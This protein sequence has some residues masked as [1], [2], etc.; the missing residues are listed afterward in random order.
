MD[1]ASIIGTIL[2]VVLL[3]GAMFMA[4]SAGGLS[5]GLYWDLTS[6]IIV[7]G[8]SLAATAIAF[9]LPKV[10]A[11][12]KLM[13][14]VFQKPPWEQ[15]ELAQKIIELS[16][17]A[18]KNVK[19]LQGEMDGI[20][21]WFLKDGVQFIIDGVQP[22]EIKEMMELRE[23]TRE[24]KESSEANVMK[25]MGDF[26]PAFGM[27]GTLIGLVIMMFSMG[28]GGEGGDDDGGGMAA[29]L[30]LSMGVALITT[31]YGALFANLIFLPFSEKLKSKN[32][33]NKKVQALIIEGVNLLAKKVH[34]IMV[35]ERLNSYLQPADRIRGEE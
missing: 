17:V 8:G 21:N 10:I 34:P 12:F 28:G 23:E 18:R 30:G 5:V 4:A 1:I 22:D 6:A 35:T 19:D 31:F 14:M 13:G 16:A 3:G 11:V 24:E 26:S 25:K 9:P 27:V 7:L 2:G 15:K 29:R 20:R 32:E 33:E